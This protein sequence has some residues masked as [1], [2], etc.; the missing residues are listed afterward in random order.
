MV[1]KIPNILII[2]QWQNPVIFGK[3]KE[4]K[5]LLILPIGGVSMPM[6]TVVK[7]KRK[8]LGLT[9]EQV[10]NYLGVSTPA[11]SK[12][13]KGVSYPDVVLMP[14]LAR[15]LETDLNTLMC[16]RE[17]L[18]R[19]EIV[20]FMNKVTEVTRKEGFEQGYALAMEKVREYPGSVELIHEIAMLLQGLLMMTECSFE[21]KETYNGYIT[22]LYERVA[23][24][25][26]P[27]FVHRA[28]YMLA[29]SLIVSGEYDRAKEMLD[30]LP[31]YNALDKRDL[32]ARLLM[33]QG[34]NDEAARILERKLMTNLQNNQMLLDNL[35]KIA[36]KEGEEQHADSLAECARKEVETFKMWEYG[37]Y[38]VPLE[39]AISKKDVH[40][41]ISILKAIL[42]AL[43]VPWDIKQS[44][45]YR[46]VDKKEKKEK[47]ENFGKQ[48]LPSLLSEMERNSE[49]DFLRS[50]PEFQQLLERYRD[51]C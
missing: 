38:V 6:N 29:S 44:P 35:A 30:T 17:E 14:P 31:E 36:V 43:L 22:Q 24:S 18:T 9:Q 10:A 7:E 37:A 28:K 50:A 12:W 46:H 47:E 48:V 20:L 42:D 5:F 32:Q 21:K 1:K 23:K 51:K 16:F 26:N 40:D 25:E 45:I 27:E 4:M 3:M 49:Y 8:E 19:K 13:E 34:K 15:L 2:S 11:V 33:E 39:V 41:S